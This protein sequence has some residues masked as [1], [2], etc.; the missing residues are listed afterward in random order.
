MSESWGSVFGAL[1][2]AAG[3][4]WPAYVRHEFVAGL[5]DGSLPKA[6]FRHYLTQDYVF[7]VHFARAWSMVV[8][9]SDS[10]DEMR[11]AA[12][13]VHAL[14][15]EEM[16]LH[17]RSCAGWGIDE[18]SLAATPEAHAN[19]AYTRFVIDAGLAGDNLDLL[20]ALA[21]CVFGYG[22]IGRRLKARSVA[23]NPYQ[24][25]IDTYGGDDYQ[26]ACERVGRLLDMVAE[27]RIGLPCEQAPRWSSLVRIFTTACRLEEDFWAMGL[28]GAGP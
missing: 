6:A 28:A 15:D 19:L 7:L 25:W 1:R 4:A 16:A 18:A 9:K 5:A 24:D 21:P 12:A 10:P 23:D 13:T 3:D 27:R 11:L 17:V 20:T 2:M 8:V 26:M 14:L 22:E